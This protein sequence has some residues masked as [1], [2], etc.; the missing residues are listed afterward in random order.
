MNQIQIFNNPE[1]GD[2][3]IVQIDDHS[4]FI[5][6]DICM[7][8]GY[9]NPRSAISQHIDFEDVVKHDIPTNSGNQLMTC[10]NESGVYSLIFGSQ[11]K[12][13]R[14]FKKWVTSEVL[15]SIRKN[16]GYIV[17]KPEDTPEVIMAKALLLAD[18]TI[19]QQAAKLELKEKRVE[20]LEEV[21]KQQAPKVLFADSVAS[22]NKSIL[23]GEL[24]KIICQNG[25]HVGQNRLFGILRQK[26]YLGVKGEYHNLPTQM[27]MN[28]GLFEIKKTSIDKPDGTILVTS[29][30]KVTGKGQIY[31]VNKFLSKIKEGVVS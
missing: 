14:A 16:G 23:I 27:A 7:V 13:A 17:T 19:K 2:I 11:L 26:G 29:T 1:F 3:R 28:L 22:S 4:F 9:S 5:A 15:P 10:I 24:A 8:L 6:N 20:L 31:F 18:N 25:Y 30:T 21:T 12:S